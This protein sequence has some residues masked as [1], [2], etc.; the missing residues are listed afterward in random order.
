MDI[1]VITVTKRI[2]Q[3]QPT[4]HLDIWTMNP[5]VVSASGDQGVWFLKKASNYNCLAY[6]CGLRVTLLKG[7]DESNNNKQ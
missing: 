3:K 7:K 5:N 2:A 4:E 6:K 1:I